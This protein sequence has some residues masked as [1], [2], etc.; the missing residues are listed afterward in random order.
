MGRDMGTFACWTCARARCFHS[1]ELPAGERMAIYGG[2]SLTLSKIRQE[3]RRDYCLQYG[4]Y[5]KIQIRIR[6]KVVDMTA[7]GPGLLA[8]CNRL[9]G[10]SDVKTGTSENVPLRWPPY[11]KCGM[12]GRIIPDQGSNTTNLSTRE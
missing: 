8:N 10:E 2:P 5:I 11:I 1:L 12:V 4:D 7:H 6:D 3:V 9:L